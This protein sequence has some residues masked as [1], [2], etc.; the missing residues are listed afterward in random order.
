MT[1]DQAAAPAEP[2]ILARTRS[3]EAKSR[4]RS[5]AARPAGLSLGE[6][7][8][9]WSAVATVIG[10]HWLYG[11]MSASAA[12]L[13][14]IGWATLTAWSASARELRRQA[15]L[16]PIVA[17]ALL[18]AF[19]IALAFWAAAAPPDLRP[20]GD[21]HPVWQGP[22]SIDP[23]ATAVQAIDL[24]GLGCAAWVGYVIGGRSE[25]ADLALRLLVYLGGLSAA[26]AI[27]NFLFG[28]VPQ[29]Q[30][31]RLEALFLNP[32]TAGCLFGTQ[33]ILAMGLAIRHIRRARISGE[34]R[35]VVLPAA[36]V[37]VCA[38]ALLLTVSRGAIAATGVALCMLMLLSFALQSRARMLNLT[39]GVGVALVGF[40]LVGALGDPLR[41]RLGS[42]D[43]DALVRRFILDTHW[44]AFQA[45]PWYGF[46]LGTFDTVNRLELSSQT[47]QF[48]WNI[49][50]AENVYLQ[51]LEESGL[52]G[53]IPMFLAIALIIARTLRGALRRARMMTW[54]LALLAVDALILLHGL[55]DFSLQTT[56]VAAFWAFA[57]GL[58][59]SLSER[60]ARQS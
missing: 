49:R 30:D 6:R 3:A 42:L 10:F 17:P 2:A 31:Q 34:W 53:A 47:F 38:V 32:N 16:R 44:R 8:F 29:I 59:L 15:D 18:F 55:V 54:L 28:A 9:V 45:S 36:C 33:L 37:F 20:L 48:L 35:G 43:D 22:R 51:W 25:R 4:R 19:V 41:T 12:M 50:S 57:L 14:A 23:S 40:Y 39:I 60:G 21:G 52:A 11:A 5:A 13:L 7:L 58:Q 24:L 46:G 26:A 1:A 27:L 56:S